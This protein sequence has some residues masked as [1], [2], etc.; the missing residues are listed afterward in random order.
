MDYL[1]E[2]AGGTLLALIGASIG[3]RKWWR[4]K[5]K[6]RYGKV[7][8]YWP[9]IG[10]GTAEEALNAVEE[11][12]R[13]PAIAA[14]RDTILLGREMRLWYALRNEPLSKAEEAATAMLHFADQH[15]KLPAFIYGSAL[16]THGCLL[17]DEESW[18]YAL[19][20]F[21]ASRHLIREAY[22]DD[23]PH[24]VPPA[25]GLAWLYF[26]NGH[27]LNAAKLLA[28]ALRVYESSLGAQHFRTA[29]VRAMLA[30][31]AYAVGLPDDGKRELEMSARMLELVSTYAARRD[32]ELVQRALIELQP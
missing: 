16:Y 13:D 25:I 20:R 26:R 9:A 2:I 31:I 24:T 27:F 17:V 1:L 18:K 5:S 23:A 22:G 29:R 21:S 4:A 28:E 3:I 7:V 30:F 15:A 8:A 19:E 14:G 11:M 10:E 6:A 32:K 12:E